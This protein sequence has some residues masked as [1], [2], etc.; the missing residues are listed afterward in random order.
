MLYEVITPGTVLVEQQVGP[1]D[2]RVHVEACDAQGVVVEPDR[3]GFLGVEVVVDRSVP[4]AA[5]AS[6]VGVP[7]DPVRREPG[8][9]V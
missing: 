7:V 4:A 5:G 9:L 1:G 8:V 3:G 2:A 6:P